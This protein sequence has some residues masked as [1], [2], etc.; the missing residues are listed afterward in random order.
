MNGW[1]K[2]DGSEEHKGLTKQSSFNVIG[3]LR[4]LAWEANYSCKIWW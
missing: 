3:S 4:F 2:H 1:A